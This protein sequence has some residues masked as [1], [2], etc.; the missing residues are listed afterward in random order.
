MVG[1]SLDRIKSKTEIGI[2]CFYI[3]DAELR[4]KIGQIGIRIMCPSRSICL[5]VDCCF[6]ELVHYKNATKHVGLV[7]SEPDDHLIGNYLVL[8]MI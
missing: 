4:R 2:C 6:S 8:T 5:S 1:T 3:K 7:Q